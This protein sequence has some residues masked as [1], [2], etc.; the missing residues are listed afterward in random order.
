MYNDNSK[1]ERNGPRALRFNYKLSILVIQGATEGLIVGGGS[2]ASKQRKSTSMNTPR[3]RPCA[4]QLPYTFSSTTLCVRIR[5]WDMRPRKPF[6]EAAL[7][8]RPL[9]LT[10]WF[11]L[12]DNKR[13]GCGVG[14]NNSGHLARTIVP[15]SPIQSRRPCSAGQLAGAPWH[16]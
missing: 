15:A 8:R 4:R 1:I 14:R 13:R 5:R 9:T 7:L 3:P 11:W 10:V 2:A 16:Q 6:M 12:V